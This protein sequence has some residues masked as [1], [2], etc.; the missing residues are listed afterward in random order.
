MYLARILTKRLAESNVQRS[1]EI[2]SGMSGDLSHISTAELLQALNLS[3]KTGTLALA[4]PKGAAQLVLK[5]GHLIRAEYCDNAGK[6]AVYE[7]LKEK[8]GRFK[9]SPD[10]PED[11]SNTP[12]IGSLMEMLL[13]TSRI[14]DEEACDDGQ[15]SPNDAVDSENLNVPNLTA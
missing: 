12:K 8:E 15:D 11:Q 9:F 2:T 6:E 5:S 14:L 13:D 4:L 10:I 7:V 3:Q 1:E